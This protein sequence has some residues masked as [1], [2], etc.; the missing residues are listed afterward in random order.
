MIGFASIGY[1]LKMVIQIYIGIILIYVIL[2]WFPNKTGVL[3][4]IDSVFEKLCDPFLKIFKKL[5]PPIGG[6]VDITP[7]IAVFALYL[8][9]YF[10]GVIFH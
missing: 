5:I 4:E 3:A 6:M 8:V 2:S 9:S 10:V 7:I 1:L